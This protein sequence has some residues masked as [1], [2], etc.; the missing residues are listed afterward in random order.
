MR[1]ACLLYKTPTLCKSD[2]DLLSSSLG[3]CTLEIGGDVDGAER[4]IHLQRPVRLHAAHIC[5]HNALVSCILAL[6][7]PLLMCEARVKG[8]GW[9]SLA[10]DATDPLCL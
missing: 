7:P 10:R 5:A 3:H 6:F 8:S 1:T 2:E 4:A 9:D